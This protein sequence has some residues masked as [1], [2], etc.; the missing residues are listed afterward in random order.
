MVGWFSSAVVAE[1]VLGHTYSLQAEM[2]SVYL[3]LSGHAG[4]ACPRSRR[5]RQFVLFLRE[6][7]HCC[8][9]YRVLTYSMEQSPS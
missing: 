5:D 2:R 1:G 8:R 6:Q 7:E 4:V 9:L 3:Q